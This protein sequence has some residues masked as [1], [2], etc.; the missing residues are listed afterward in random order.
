MKRSFTAR[1]KSRSAAAAVLT[2]ALG[3]AVYLN[4]NF[5]RA[6]PQELSVASDAIET[7]AQTA[8]PVTDPLETDTVAA[9]APA[10]DMAAETG[11]KNYG[12]AQLVSVNKDSGSEFFETA[13]L[14]RSKAR[15]E[16]LDT[17]K[18]SLKNTKLTAEEKQQLT[19][20]LSDRVS[21]IT[22]ESKLETL[23]KAKGFADCV[24]DL[25]DNKANVT[26]MT[27]KDALTADEVT[28]IRDALLNQCK[29]L[30]AQD[31]T[32]VEVK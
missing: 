1:L 23:I 26:V 30:T 22:L 21:S 10:E 20:E 32:I 8:I 25:Q 29:D 17:L 5:A 9:N 7:S 15:D 24:V 31:I 4:W 12:E 19:S 28:R 3:A 16:A 11:D 18:K 2:L 27:E 13:R 6:A 14:T